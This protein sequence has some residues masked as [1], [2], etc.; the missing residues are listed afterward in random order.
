MGAFSCE[1]AKFST[2]THAIEK[3]SG[4]QS[5]APNAVMVDAI[6]FAFFCNRN[7]CVLRLR[8]QGLRT[9]LQKRGGWF[10]LLL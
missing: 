7:K 6:I 9:S 10:Q 4:P 5:D 2:L 3:I 8:S 1:L